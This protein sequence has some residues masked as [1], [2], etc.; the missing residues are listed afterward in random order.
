MFGIVNT[1]A[2]WGVGDYENVFVKE[3]GVWKLGY[4][5]GYYTM[6]TNYEDGWTKKATPIFGEYGRLPPDRKQTIPYAAYPSAFVP[7]F[8]YK[9]P[10]SGRADHYADPTFHDSQKQ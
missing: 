8:H 2:Q 10:V 7:P 4:L 3:D 5:H 9:N 1:N 6:Y